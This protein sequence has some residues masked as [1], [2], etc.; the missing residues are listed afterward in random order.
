MTEKSYKNISKIRGKN[1]KI[2]IALRKALWNKGYRYS[3]NCKAL[4]RNPDIILTNIGLLSFVIVNFFMDWKVLKPLWKKGKNPY[5]WVK[6][7]ERNIQRDIEKDQALQHLG[8][9]VIHFGGNDIMKNPDECIHVMEKTII[10]LVSRSNYN[11]MGN[12]SFQGV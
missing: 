11:Y 10:G 5:Y 9:T 2:E 3:K 8:W 4:P 7:I 12:R 1:T 6:K